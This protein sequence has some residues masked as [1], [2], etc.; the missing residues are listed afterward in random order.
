MWWVMLITGR[1][2]TR[3]EITFNLQYWL[4]L[5][6]VGE[7]VVRPDILLRSFVYDQNVPLP[8]FLKPVPWTCSFF[9]QLNSIFHPE[10]KTHKHICCGDPD[11]QRWERADW[12]VCSVLLGYIASRITRFW[13]ILKLVQKVTF[14]IW[15]FCFYLCLRLE[16]IIFLFYFETSFLVCLI[17]LLLWLSAYWY[18]LSCH[19][20]VQLSRPRLCHFVCSHLWPFLVFQFPYT[21]V[22]L[23]IALCPCAQCLL[24]RWISLCLSPCLF[25]GH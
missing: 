13:N 24:F 14:C 16:F 9:V 8:I 21:S 22:S 12:M 6:T 4:G 1:D 19:T 7:G 15:T 5:V 10:E 3:R 23:N 11:K 20:W 18:N 25:S 17:F 2:A